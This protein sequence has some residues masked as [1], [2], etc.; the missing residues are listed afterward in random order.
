MAQASPTLGIHHSSAVYT[1]RLTQPELASVAKL[2]DELTRS[3]GSV[4]T[5]EF[6]DACTLCAQQL[7]RGLRELAHRFKYLHLPYGAILLRGVPVDDERIGPSPSHWDA[8]WRNPPTL[9]EEVA[10]CLL[11]AALGDIFGWRTQENGRFLRHI[12]PIEKDRDEQLGGGSRVT[13]V[14][15]NEEAFHEYRSDF[16]SILC[17]RNDEQAETVLSHVGDIDIPGDKWEILSAPRFVILPDKSHLPDQNISS[18]WRL[19]DAAFQHVRRMYA[20]PK[21]VAALSGSR[22]RPCIQVDEAFMRAVDGD[23][24]AARAFE[25]LLREFD[26]RKHGI[27]MQPGDLLWIDNKRTVHGRSVY[28][29]NYGPRHRWLRRV[30]VTLNLRASLPYRESPTARQ[31]V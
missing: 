1:H 26:A 11:T 7:P 17:Y 29:P 30:N 22:R 27:V 13:L 24:E 2:V 28:Q 21:P 4:E 25:W 18:Q 3:F 15:H 6:A 16:L 9:R 31:I 23:T 8:P 5:P 10:Q 14:W 12:V 20:E 19:E